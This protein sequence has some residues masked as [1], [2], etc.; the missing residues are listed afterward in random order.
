MNKKLDEYCSI[1][2]DVACFCQ[3]LKET[4]ASEIK[5]DEIFMIAIRTIMIVNTATKKKEPYKFEIASIKLYVTAA[6][7]LIESRAM[8]EGS[9][10]IAS[11]PLLIQDGLRQIIQTTNL[12]LSE[13]TRMRNDLTELQASLKSTAVHA[14]DLAFYSTVYIIFFISIQGEDDWRA[15]LLEIIREYAGGKSNE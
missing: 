1:A 7:L 6:R 3:A 10:K 15:S 2:S 11:I 14:E 12:L 8:A 4:I 9:P 5:R 13:D